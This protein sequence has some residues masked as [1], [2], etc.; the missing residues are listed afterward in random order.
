MRLVETFMGAASRAKRRILMTQ[1]ESFAVAISSV[2]LCVSFIALWLTHLSGFAPKV[3]FG[4][5]TLTIY[6]I[7]P[8]ESGNEHGETWYIPSFNF[9]VSFYNSGSRPGDIVDMRLRVF[10]T[11]DAINKEFIFYPRWIVNYAEF[12]LHRTERFAWL[13]SAVEREWYPI[14]L[15]ARSSP[16]DLHLILE[17]GR[18]DVPFSGHL[19]LSLEMF[20][21]HGDRWRGL[22]WYEMPIE[23][24]DFEEKATWTPFDERLRR[25]R[26]D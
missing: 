17:A 9:G 5:P 2:S 18:W 24:G 20:S 7:T 16:V 4:T 26:G 21:S 8:A 6:K 12:S 14:T 25:T 1:A 19:E 10:V 13:A 11:S 3:N 15:S 22:A 23:K